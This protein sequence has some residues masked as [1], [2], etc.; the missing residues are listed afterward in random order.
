MKKEKINNESTK[1]YQ[2]VEEALDQKHEQAKR[3]LEKVDLSKI[4]SL[5]SK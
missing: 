4:A 3:F 1:V 2:S 5:T